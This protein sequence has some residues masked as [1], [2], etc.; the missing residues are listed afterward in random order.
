MTSAEIFLNFKKSKA[1]NINKPNVRYNYIVWSAF[2][3]PL[4]NDRR[5]I[6]FSDVIRFSDISSDNDPPANGIEVPSKYIRGEG[7]DDLPDEEIANRI[8]NWAGEKSIERTSI[9]GAYSPAGAIG[10]FGRLSELS[11]EDQ[12]RILVPLDIVMKLI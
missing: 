12:K 11:T 3:K 8:E 4:T 7:E 5:F 9:I 2:S 6:L 10:K 1:L